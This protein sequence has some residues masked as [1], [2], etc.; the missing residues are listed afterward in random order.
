MTHYQKEALVTTTDRSPDL[1]LFALTLLLTT[2]SSLQ[3][4]WLE[5]PHSADWRAVLEDLQFSDV[6][7]AIAFMGR[8]RNR[9]VFFEGAGSLLREMTEYPEPPPHPP[10][11]AAREIVRRLA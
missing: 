3:Q 4:I 7:A 11:D 8:L 9:R 2:P 10:N 6:D 5:S 1:Q